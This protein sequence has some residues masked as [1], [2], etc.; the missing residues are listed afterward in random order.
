MESIKIKGFSLDERSPVKVTKMG[1][2]TEIQYMEKRNTKATI[3]K[4]DKENYIL[5]ST[6]EVKQFEHNE[7]RADDKRSIQ[8]TMYMGRTIINT[9]VTD[10]KKAKFITGTYKENMTDPKKLYEDYKYFTKK[11]KKVYG[12]FE[13]IV[14]IEPQER[15]AWHFHAILIFPSRAPFMDN[16]D[17][18]SIWNRGI[19]YTEKLD[20]VDNVGAYLTAYLTDVPLKENTV[21]KDGQSIKIAE[22][23]KKYIKGER[24]KYYP[25]GMRIFRYS[26]GIKKPDVEFMTY[27]DA[28]K[29]VSHA[30]LTYSSTTQIADDGFNNLIHKEYYNKIRK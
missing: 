4:I 5:L 12:E 22:N 21:P 11:L 16:R 14:A 20:D 7:T 9:N 25:S 19:T 8:K 2:I 26:K 10:V 29:E 3:Q 24:L 23:G 28:K 13:Y 17:V 27:K 15:G 1:N 18:Q 30:Q 6:G